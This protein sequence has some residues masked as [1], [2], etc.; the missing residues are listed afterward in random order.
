MSRV[1]HAAH[2]QRAVVGEVQAFV[3]HPHHAMAVFRAALGV[4]IGE[5][6]AQYP[7]ARAEAAV[8]DGP[9]DPR[10]RGIRLSAP[11][12]WPTVSAGGEEL[13]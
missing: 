8:D 1:E 13:A 12:W 3:L 10:H 9:G 4:T 6:L 7:I 2:A 5:Y 11:S